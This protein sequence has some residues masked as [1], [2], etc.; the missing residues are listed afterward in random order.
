MTLNEIYS[1]GKLD[2]NTGRLFLNHHKKSDSD[3]SSASSS[4]VEVA[5]AYYRAGYTPTDY[6]TEVEWAARELIESSTAIKCPSIGYHLSGAKAIQAALYREGVLEDL[7]GK[8]KKA[9]CDKLRECFIE[10]YFLG[11]PVRTDACRAAIEE[12]TSH[13]KNWVLKPQREGQ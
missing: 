12:A 2:Q 8:E 7:L 13:G 5:I 6:P 10:Q 11:D 1:Y 9:D 4:V 3:P